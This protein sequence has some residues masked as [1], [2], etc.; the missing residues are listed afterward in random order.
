[1][2]LAVRNSDVMVAAAAGPQTLQHTVKCSAAVL[3]TL[4]VCIK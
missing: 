1:M 3:V 2:H 4:L